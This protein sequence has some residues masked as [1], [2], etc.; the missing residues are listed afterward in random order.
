MAITSNCNKFLF[1]C[2]KLGADYKLTLTLGRLNLYATKKD[3]ESCIEFFGNNAKAVTDVEFA[4]EYCEPLLEILG[5]QQVDSID[6]SD[7]ENPTLVHDLNKP[8]PDH[9][10]NKYS[11]VIDGGTI[12][13][14]FNFPAAIKNCMEMLKEGGH[15]IGV[16]PV[17]NLMGH[18]FY[19]FSPELYYN[20]F[21]KENG[22]N[23]V[24]ILVCT[25]KSNGIYSDWYEVVNPRKIKSRVM[26]TNSL[27]T[28][29]M[30][31]AQKTGT[32]AIFSKTPQ[33]SDYENI[34]AIKKAL[35]ENKAPGNDNK[36]RFLYR[37]VTPKPLKIFLHN[38]YDLFTKQK[39]V[40]EGL[41]EINPEQ[42]K[43]INLKE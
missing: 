5:A 31:I 26:F 30:V 29:L 37:K 28:Y 27:P 33:Q 1:Y 13:H 34:W 19:Q 20:I 9:L 22:F 32:E 18:G 43:R 16:T 40:E 12:E 25:Q 41:G 2:K 21:S 14:I 23:V 24:K 17:N 10:K 36:I 15:Y 7:Y 39:V 11:A 3:I 35:Q 42:F 38:I 6:Y 4:D 8:I